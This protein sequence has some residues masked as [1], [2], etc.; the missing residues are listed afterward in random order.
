M[1]ATLSAVLR[2]E[3]GKQKAIKLR[4]NGQVPGVL[5]GD[6]KPSENI[7]VS[8]QELS[9]LLLR[10]GSGKLINLSIKKGKKTEE[11][12]VLIKEFQRHPIKGNLLHIDFLRVAMDRPVIVKVPVHLQNEEK[13]LKDGGILE[14]VIHEVEVS[15]LPSNIPDRI[16]VDVSKLSIGSGI[17]IKDLIVPEGVRLAGSPDEVVV[18]VASPTVAIEATATEP[19]AAEPEIV[20]GKKEG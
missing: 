16:L 17:H 19:S 1:A 2:E 9:R 18:L 12:H 3:S 15:C 7:S 14:Q 8:A 5:Y 20:G 6:G 10:N 13:R 4:K 11:E